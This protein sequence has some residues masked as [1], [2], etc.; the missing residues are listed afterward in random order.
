MSPI[1]NEFDN[2][3]FYVCQDSEILT[4]ECPESAIEDYLD[5]Q[6][7]P[8]C[9]IRELI[10]QLSPITVKAFHRVAIDDDDLRKISISLLE[11]A[12]E[13]FAEHWGNPDGLDDDDLNEVTIKEHLPAMIE[14]VRAFYSH[15]TVW[16]CEQAATRKYSEDEVLEI[17]IDYYPELETEKEE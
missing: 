3:D 12:A 10:K 8:G 7:V 1:T 9:D 14:T 16:P 17:M 4:H 13:N 5:M 2:A 15:G 11:H 6:A